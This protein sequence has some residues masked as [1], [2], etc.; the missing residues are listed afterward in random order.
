[1]MKRI[2]IYTIGLITFLGVASCQNAPDEQENLQEKPI[3]LRTGLKETT[4]VG[5]RAP[6][7]N[8]DNT[9]V[10]IL[11]GNSSNPLSFIESWPAKISILKNVTFNPGHIYPLTNETVVLRGF[12]PDPKETVEGSRSVYT[13]SLADGETDILCSDVVSGAYISPITAEMKFNHLTSQLQVWITNDGSFPEF[14]KITK[15][16]LL[17]LKVTA[18]LDVATGELT[19]IGEETPVV[20]YDNGEGFTYPIN[21]FSQIGKAVMIQPEATDVKVKMS[22]NDNTVS[23]YPIHF[24]RVTGNGE[25][26]LAGVAYQVDFI[27]TSFRV[28][29]TITIQAWKSVGKEIDAPTIW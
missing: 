26:P 9:K 5:T 19:F 3:I 14:R 10:H 12:Y 4:T 11:R 16:E 28:V 29:P 23:T 6:I 13:Y 7:N 17:G 8:F 27:M 1:M 2:S 15:L 18:Q 24:N 25:V 21:T 20:L 22:F